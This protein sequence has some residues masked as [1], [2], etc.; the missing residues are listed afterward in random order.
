M[1][2]A[3]RL[4]IFGGLPGTGK[5]EISRYLAQTLGA[6]HLRVGVIEEALRGRIGELAGPE[7]YE[8]AYGLA[9]DNLRL[10]L[11]VVADSVNPL[12]VTRRAWRDVGERARV[13]CREV[14]VV[15]SDAAEHRH[16]VETRPATVAGLR[17]PTWQEVS[18]REYDA[19]GDPHLRI[20]TAGRTPEES[21]RELLELLGLRRSSKADPSRNLVSMSPF[22]IVADLQA[23]IAY[24]LERLGFRL[25]FQGPAGDPFYG[26]VSRDG[27]GIMLKAI[28]PDVPPLPNRTRHEWARWDAYVVV[29]D[30]DSLF[31]EFRGR[32]ASFVSE[33]SFI[34]RGLWGFEVADADGYVLASSNYETNRPGSAR[35]GHS[36]AVE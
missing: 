36:P 6:V 4:Y 19:W 5:S 25:D 34:D 18:D 16:R 17:L 31:E 20:D 3:P 13:S 28:L 29:D 35:S 10:G 14:E 23:S 32:G 2:P 33:P 27:V 30:P 12:E 22:F 11:A 15:C 9:E 26:R 24:Y 1:I 8:V 7:G 21:K